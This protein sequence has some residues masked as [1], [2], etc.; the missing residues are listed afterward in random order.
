MYV[1]D[2]VVLNHKGQ[3]SSKSVTDGLAFVVYKVVVYKV[4]CVGTLGSLEEL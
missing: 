3:L 2:C 1:G 4:L